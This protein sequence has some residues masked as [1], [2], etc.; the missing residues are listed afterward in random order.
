MPTMSEEPLPTG[1][2]VAFLIVV[3]LF[4]GGLVT[5]FESRTQKA[6][7]ERWAKEETKVQKQID[8]FGGIGKVVEILDDK[9][10]AVIENLHGERIHAYM[11]PFLV[12]RGDIYRLEPTKLKH[13][14]YE[15]FEVGMSERLD[16]STINR[17]GFRFKSE[18]EL[19]F[20]F[21]HFGDKINQKR[22][23]NA[24]ST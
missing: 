15:Y 12:A 2:A 13:N 1:C 7:Q 20:L 11:Q 16:S 17:P 24:K 3:V 22:I 19:E 6:R 4:C 21:S 8:N 23:E 14:S 10:A 18:I 5:T 9:G